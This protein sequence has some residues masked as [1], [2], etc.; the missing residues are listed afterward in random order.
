VQT[1]FEVSRRAWQERFTHVAEMVR[2][3][4]VRSK[5]VQA[6]YAAVDQEL[7][8]VADIQRSLLPED[9]PSVP[10]ID[11]AVHYQTAH[12]T[13]GD[14]Y[15]FFALPEGKWGILLADACGHGAPATMM[16]AITHG[17]AH[18]Y[19]GTS[20]CP[21]ELLSF[22]NRHLARRVSGDNDSFVT[23]FYGVYDP[24]RRS[25]QFAN[26]GH[27]PPRVK[28]GRSGSLASLDAA[29]GL[30][31]GVR[32]TER[33]VDETVQLGL[34]DTIVFYTDGVTEATG[35]GRPRFGV[36]GIDVAFRE[37]SGS[38]EELLAKLLRSLE[39]FTNSRPAD[40]DRT[41][42]VAQIVS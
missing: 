26:A 34:G 37:S 30:P 6:A 25:L 39:R 31:L 32:G 23:A 18:S 9:L 38:A 17:I 2:A 15:D 14:Y 10:T 21:S 29:A 20:T 35:V 19:S 42:L 3:L 1:S 8:M 27:H 13:G 41:L 16:M 40:D 22:L 33:Y 24:A 11:L 36:E 5:Q 4:R 7:R 28:R 12:R